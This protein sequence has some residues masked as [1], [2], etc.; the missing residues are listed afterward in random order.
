MLPR[1]AFLWGFV[2]SIGIEVV[3]AYQAISTNQ[4]RLPVRFKR[5][6]YIVVRLLLGMMAGGLAVAYQTQGPLLAVHVGAATPLIL[7]TFAR[8]IPGG[9]ILSPEE[10]DG[11]TPRGTG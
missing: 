11:R 1:E 5:I 6:P 10:R 4:G 8:V 2:G 9:R 7:Q 3:V